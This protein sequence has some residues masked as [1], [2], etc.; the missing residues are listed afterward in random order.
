VFS[1]RP[2]GEFEVE[3]VEDYAP[4]PGSVAVVGRET[5]VVNGGRRY[6]GCRALKVAYHFGKYIFVGPNSI[7][8][9]NEKGEM[10]KK[11]ELDHQ[12]ATRGNLIHVSKM[13]APHDFDEGRLK[14]VTIASLVPYEKIHLFRLDLKRL[15]LVELKE[16]ESGRYFEDVRKFFYFHVEGL[17]VFVLKDRIEFVGRRRNS[18]GIRRLF[19]RA[20]ILDADVRSY[21]YIGDVM[22]ILAKGKKAYVKVLTASGVKEAFEVDCPDPRS[23]ALAWSALAVVCSGEASLWVAYSKPNKIESLKGEYTKVRVDEPY[24]GLLDGGSIRVYEVVPRFGLNFFESLGTVFRG[25]A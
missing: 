8:V 21:P 23:V 17:F 4:G 10:L 5:Y 2:L 20:E 3:D 18:V 12:I 24:M 19:G 6:L 1:L 11:F 22:A 15:E 13:V 14:V 16:I 9:T 7:C 25:R